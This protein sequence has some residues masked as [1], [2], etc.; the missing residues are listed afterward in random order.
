M[1]KIM[2]MNNM[3][4]TLIKSSLNE[5]IIKNFYQFFK[6]QKFFEI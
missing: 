6:K 1:L 2:Y 3:N 4:H 5:L